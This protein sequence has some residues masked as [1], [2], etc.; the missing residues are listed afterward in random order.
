MLPHVSPGRARPKSGGVEDARA[1]VEAE[2]AN[3]DA[4]KLVKNGKTATC[5]LLWLTRSAK[6]RGV[7]ACACTHARVH[8]RTNERTGAGMHAHTHARTQHADAAMVRNASV[9][10]LSRGCDKD[11]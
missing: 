11:A 6:A 5:A 10:A 4:A 3:G 1:L 9:V 8:A 7:R 2:L